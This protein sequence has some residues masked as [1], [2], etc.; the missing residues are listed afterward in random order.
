MYRILSTSVLCAAIAIACNA[1]RTGADVA[2]DDTA[3]DATPDVADDTA[4]SDADRP[5]AD[6][7]DVTAVDADGLDAPTP[8]PDECTTDDECVLYED[9]CLC[10]ASAGDLSGDLAACPDSPP[11][12]QTACS[13]MGVSAA[14]CLDGRCVLDTARCRS[15]LCNAIPPECP[16]GRVPALDAAGTCWSGSCVLPTDCGAL[17]CDQ[18]G[19]NDVCWQ[20]QASGEIARCYPRPAACADGVTCGCIGPEA[21]AACQGG[22]DTSAE[23]LLCLDGG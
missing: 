7:P 15:A 17:P 1:S 20:S 22:C 19:A 3:V 14:R 9:C 18:C 11:C 21:S 10:G 5:D 16:P 13:A 2:G 4:A 6:R 12:F 8:V 23:G